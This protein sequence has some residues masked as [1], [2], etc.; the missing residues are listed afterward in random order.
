MRHDAR[1]A[2]QSRITNGGSDP[3]I[4]ITCA[5]ISSGSVP[6]AGLAAISTTACATAISRDDRMSHASRFPEERLDGNRRRRAISGNWTIAAST[7][8][9]KIGKTCLSANRACNAPQNVKTSE[10][11]S[12]INQRAFET[13]CRRPSIA[14]S[15]Y[16][17]RESQ[18]LRERM[19]W[20]LALRQSRL[21]FLRKEN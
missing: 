17:R 19:F 9:V 5:V 6:S 8:I 7:S 1:S 12:Y 14:M 18:L 21:H 2:S 13:V 4:V 20:R 15:D 10:T 16:C 11:N 3:A